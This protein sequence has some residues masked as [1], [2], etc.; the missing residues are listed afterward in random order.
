MKRY[1]S[2]RG[3]GRFIKNTME[4]T[5]GLHV[6]ICPHCRICNPY[7]VNEPKPEKCHDCGKFLREP[8]ESKDER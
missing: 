5:F 3:N 2:R 8:E 4:N 7:K 6:E 1:Q